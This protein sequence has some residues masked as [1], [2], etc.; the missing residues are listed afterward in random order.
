VGAAEAAK[1]LELQLL[2]RVFL[3][4]GGS[5]IALF[6]LGARKRDDVSH[7]YSSL[8]EATCLTCLTDPTLSLFDD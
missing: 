7:C 4:L 8:L 6:A 3:V 2:R 1:L 5:I